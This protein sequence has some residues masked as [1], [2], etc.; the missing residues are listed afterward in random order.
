MQSEDERRNRSHL[1]A[2]IDPQRYLQIWQI[3]EKSTGIG[4]IVFFG[5]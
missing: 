3:R 5:P 2:K 4:W 1:V